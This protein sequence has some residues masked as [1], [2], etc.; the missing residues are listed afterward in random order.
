[1]LSY[2]EFK[3]KL[4]TEV[5]VYAPEKYKNAIVDIMGVP[6]A[7]GN[8]DAIIMRMPDRN[9]GASL[10]C[11]DLYADYVK[12]NS[13]E[14]TMIRC[15]QSLIPYMER[16]DEIDIQK[17]MNWEEVKEIIV[18]ELVC[19]RRAGENLEDL[20]YRNVE[21]TDLAIIYRVKQQVANIV[22]SIKVS[23]QM[24]ETWGVDENRIHEFAFHNMN[25]LS[26]LQIVELNS[27]F[28]M[29]EETFSELP[30]KMNKYS[31][32]VF[33]NKE[34]FYGAIRGWKLP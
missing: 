20:I 18:P 12:S 4:V 21:G 7:E 33:T 6:K 28:A 16:D 24:M 5:T 31:S 8:V 27:D 25:Q 2:E 30:E 1:M 34:A 29:P 19:T 15:L 17:I 32:Y 22:G 10:N 14:K 23:K 9:S 13:F 11:K 3:E 26:T